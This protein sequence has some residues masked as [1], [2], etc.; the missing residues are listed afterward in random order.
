[1]ERGRNNFR[2]NKQKQN[3]FSGFDSI[4]IQIA[5]LMKKPGKESRS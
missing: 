5:D 2:N 4:R 3:L 1:M